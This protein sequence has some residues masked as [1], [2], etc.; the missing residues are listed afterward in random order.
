M[1]EDIGIDFL[2]TAFG[3]WIPQGIERTDCRGGCAGKRGS[4]E[5]GEQAAQTDDTEHGP[6]R[7]VVCRLGRQLRFEETTPSTGF[8]CSGKERPEKHRM[9]K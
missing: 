7:A 3:S 1:L 8:G 5:S 6:R 2:K 9:M 4:E